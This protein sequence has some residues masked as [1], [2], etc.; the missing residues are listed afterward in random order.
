M[1][2]INLC[3][4]C[5]GCCKHLAIE[6]DTPTDRDDYEDIYWYLLHENIKIFVTEKDIED[7]EDEDD[8]ESWFIEFKTRCK[9]LQAN[10]LCSLHNDNKNLQKK[11]L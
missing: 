2:K 3:R 6:I 4:G 10:N 5:G 7:K 11:P 8:L 9:E 1:A